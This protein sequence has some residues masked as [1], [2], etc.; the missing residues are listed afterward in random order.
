MPPVP[1]PEVPNK[2]SITAV[3]LFSVALVI[4]IAILTV[5]ISI[6]LGHRQSSNEN[7]EPTNTDLEAGKTNPETASWKSTAAFE[8]QYEDNT[9][10]TT[11]L[12][13]VETSSSVFQ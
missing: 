11:D 6:F 1:T 3:I 8:A 9:L 10:L 13:L 12:E 4:A 7:H 2:W 5:G